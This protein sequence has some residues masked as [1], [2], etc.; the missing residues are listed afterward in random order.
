MIDYSI[1]WSYIV[2]K[3]SEKCGIKPDSTDKISMGEIERRIE[4]IWSEYC[5]VLDDKYSKGE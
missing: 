2:E 5:D 3:M 1:T 4:D